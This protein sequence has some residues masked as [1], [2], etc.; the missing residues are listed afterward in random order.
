MR[1]RFVALALAAG[2]AT[3]AATTLPAV[4]GTEPKP[5]LTDPAGDANGINGQI[6]GLPVPSTPTGPASYAAGDITSV[7]FQSTF[8]KKGRKKVV[9]GFT[10][11]MT[12]AAAPDSET[13]YGITVDIPTCPDGVTFAY[14][15][16]QLFGENN[17]SCFDN[18]ASSIT[19]LGAPPAVVKGSTITWTVPVAVMPKGTVL[20]NIGA[21]TGE[22]VI[23]DEPVIDDATT[24]AT[25]TVGK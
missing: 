16:Q 10:A 13:W 2:A 19:D 21:H 25:Y 15:T 6:F 3:T 14:S 22:L 7:L 17:V 18:A 5:Q 4:A 23:G 20:T 24:T 12:L 8:A 1:R 11:T 9:T